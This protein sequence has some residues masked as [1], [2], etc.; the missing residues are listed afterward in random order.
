MSD[1]KLERDGFYL[2]RG[3][4]TTET[5]EEL[6]TC[7][8]RVFESKAEG[9]LA[10]SGSGQVYAARNL[11][12]TLPEARSIWKVG[13][14]LSFLTRQLGPAFGLVRALYF[15]KPP[16]QS[17]SLQWHRDLAIAV[18]DN[19]LPSTVL[20]RPNLKAGV[21]HVIASE[22][23]LQN[24]LTLRIHLDDVTMENGPLWVKPGTHAGLQ[25]FESPDR[26]DEPILC[27]AGDVLA[28]RP[29]LIHCSR[30]STPGTWR[31]RRILHLEFSSHA[32][33]PDGY[34]WYDFVSA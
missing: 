8:D 27:N 26:A 21:P 5:V 25:V 13:T 22:Q 14:L 31:R 28:M 23:V 2:L 1:N 32:E 19:S 12:R 16:D 11:A 3:A 10:R 18:E 17:W 29:M 7:C 9:V 34:R 30:N 15:D 24:M 4:V 6:K 33:L 20:T